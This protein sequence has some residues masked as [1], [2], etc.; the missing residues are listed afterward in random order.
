MSCARYIVLIIR[1]ELV[2]GD[3]A[4]LFSLEILG[5]L[6]TNHEPLPATHNINHLSTAR[7]SSD[8]TPSHKPRSPSTACFTLSTIPP[9]HIDSITVGCALESP[10][11]NVSR[12]Y[13]VA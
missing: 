8:T 12:I 4:T 2:C 7:A 5:H 10:A 3:G 1:K 13:P 9:Q 11:E 6:T